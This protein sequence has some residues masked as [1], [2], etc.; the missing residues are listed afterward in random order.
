MTQINS[1]ENRMLAIMQAAVKAKAAG[2]PLTP[3]EVFALHNLLFTAEERAQINK[4]L[5]ED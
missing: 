1:L 4:T 3:H 2:K 5:L